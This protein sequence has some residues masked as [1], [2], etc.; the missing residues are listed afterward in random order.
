MSSCANRGDY[1]RGVLGVAIKQMASS[2]PLYKY[3]LRWYC[4]LVY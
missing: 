1:F 2:S 4:L 3:I